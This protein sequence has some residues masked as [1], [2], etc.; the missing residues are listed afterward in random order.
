MQGNAGFVNV[1]VAEYARHAMD[2]QFADQSKKDCRRAFELS[3]QFAA[4]CPFHQA[5]L[6]VQS[7][8]KSANDSGWKLRSGNLFTLWQLVK[9]DTMHSISFYGERV[10]VSASALWTICGYSADD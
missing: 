2:A 5:T 6:V 1:R 9:S 4:A 3:R 10:E 7:I 8:L